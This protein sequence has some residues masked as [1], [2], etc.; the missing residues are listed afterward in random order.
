M[1]NIHGKKKYRKFFKFLRKNFGEK[2]PGDINFIFENKISR[3]EL[4]QK[5]INLKNFNSYLEIG[6]F[7]DELFSEITCKTKIGVDPVSGGNIRMTSDD[8]FLQNKLTF[9]CIFI[10]GLHH[11]DQVLKDIDNSLKVLNKNGIIFI[12]DCL[13]MNMDA[14]SIPRTVSHWNGDVWKAFVSKRTDPR[15]DCYTIYADEGIGSILKRPNKNILKLDIKNFKK[16]KY[17]DFYYNHRAYMNIVE[18][19]DFIKII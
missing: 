6:T 15:L 18:A 17:S 5:V 1:S 9:D 11:Y 19:E 16:M 2:N 4:V 7:K 13:P 14:Q 8:F 10:D 3:I 12:H